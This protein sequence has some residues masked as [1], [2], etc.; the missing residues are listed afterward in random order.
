MRHFSSAD[1][2]GLKITHN[3]KDCCE[4]NKRARALYIVSFVGMLVTCTWLTLTLG[5]LLAG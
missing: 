2:R 4:L 1:I 5:N 3:S